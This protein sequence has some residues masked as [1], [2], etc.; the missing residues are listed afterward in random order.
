MSIYLT[1]T[2]LRGERFTHRVWFTVVGKAWWNSSRELGCVAG[3]VHTR[4]QKSS[5]Q[6]MTFKPPT[7]KGPLPPAMRHF[8]TVPPKT[9]PQTEDNYSK[10]RSKRVISDS[11]YNCNRVMRIE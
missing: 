5:I 9:V 11:N 6:D 7:H 10:H 8:L 2:V 3:S 4:K 1:E